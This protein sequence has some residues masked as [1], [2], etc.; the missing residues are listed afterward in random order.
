MY[1]SGQLDRGVAGACIPLKRGRW[2]S[3]LPPRASAASF[4]LDGT[5]S[6][7]VYLLFQCLVEYVWLGGSGTDL[8]SKTK[9]M[10]FKPTTP[11]E[12]PVIVVDVS[13][14]PG[15]P[16]DELLCEIFLKPRKI[17]RDP[18]RGGDHVLVLCDT[19]QPPE[20]GCC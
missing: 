18:F 15:Q 1:S 9:V 20:V 12:V 2:Y 5:D 6:C 16:P 11:E 4:P 13:R 10:A 8:R 14:S 3:T 7:F 17:F 19:F